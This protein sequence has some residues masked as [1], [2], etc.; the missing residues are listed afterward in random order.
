M[1][2]FFYLFATLLIISSLLVI[3]SNNPIYSVLWLIFAFCNAS[4]LIILTG[5]EFL[6]MILIIIY[7]GAVAVL[8][9]FVIMMLNTNLTLIKKEK[10]KNFW[11]SI[12]ISIF[13]LVDLAAIILV[14]TKSLSAKQ[15]AKHSINENISNIHAIGSILY[16]DFILPF[17]LAGIILFTAMIASISLTLQIRKKGKEQNIANQL[18]RN[19]SNS[20]ILS[21]VGISSG[22]EGLEYDK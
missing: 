8:F 22:I 1:I 4:G 15:L 12:L 13:V 14:A 11:L 9:L 20:I 2:L 5:A 16:T 6:A 19:K 3:I 10:S 17:Q 21:K 18:A 7:V